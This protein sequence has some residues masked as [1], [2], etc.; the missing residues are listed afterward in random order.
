M[1]REDQ[2][3]AAAN[4]AALLARPDASADDLSVGDVGDKFVPWDLF[5]CLYGSYSSAFDDMALAV[6]ENIRDGKCKAEDLASEMF[7]EILCTADL[8]EYGTSPRVCFPTE[9]FKALLPQLIARWE[10]YAKAQ[11]GWGEE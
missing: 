5:P 10:R 9:E 7:R 2:K 8:C 4:V 1:H 11:W 3:K 6:L